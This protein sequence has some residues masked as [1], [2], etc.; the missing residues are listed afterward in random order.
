MTAPSIVGT[1]DLK[2]DV[3]SLASCR[4]LRTR[5]VRAIYQDGEMTS[6]PLSH[7]KK[8]T[9]LRLTEQVSMLHTKPPHR[10]QRYLKWQR[11]R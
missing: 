9:K 3:G 4:L 7:G 1:S 8:T 10:L 6:V 11:L 5:R 2:P